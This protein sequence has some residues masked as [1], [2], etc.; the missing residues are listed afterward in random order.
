MNKIFKVLK[1]TLAQRGIK[2]GE[3]LDEYE[4]DNFADYSFR[5]KGI[6]RWRFGL[7]VS[8]QY[9]GDKIRFFAIHEDNIDKFKPSRAND[10]FCVEYILVEDD[11]SWWVT[12]AERIIR[13]IKR[14]PI[15]SYNIDTTWSGTMPYNCPHIV[16]YIIYRKKVIKFD[17]KQWYRDEFKY[18][19]TYRHLKK[20]KRKL[21]KLGL[22]NEIKIID[23]NDEWGYQYPRYTLE[24]HFKPYRIIDDTTSPDAI[25]EWLYAQYLPNGKRADN[26]YDIVSFD[27]N[28]YD[29]GWW[30]GVPDKRDFI[31]VFG[32]R[33][34]LSKFFRRVKK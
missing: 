8:S 28:G 6:K 33:Y 10:I 7:W 32:W 22:Y 20:V 5:I 1:D 31:E 29:V 11:A 34:K 14:H 3:I 25:K 2:I 9:E 17:V 19:K 26:N 21:F 16:E 12:S 15:I 27:A 24:L 4:G 23:E 30:S 13:M 18:N